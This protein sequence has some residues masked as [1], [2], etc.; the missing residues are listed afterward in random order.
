MTRPRSMPP[1]PTLA[2]HIGLFFLIVYGA[3]GIVGFGIYGTIGVAASA[4]ENA[5]WLAFVAAMVA[6][7]L[8]GHVRLDLLAVPRAAG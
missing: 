5:V 6:A 4:M 7:M 1:G 8:T 3:G 2:R